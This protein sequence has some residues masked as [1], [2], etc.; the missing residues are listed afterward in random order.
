MIK[1]RTDATGSPIKYAE[2]LPLSRVEQLI[3]SGKASA[4]LIA[5]YEAIKSG[6]HMA[7][8][9]EHK[10]KSKEWKKIMK[11]DQVKARVRK[12]RNLKKQES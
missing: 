11:R 10:E 8:I 2:D 9:H 3:A 1:P 12:H 7:V 4:D 6:N 5:A